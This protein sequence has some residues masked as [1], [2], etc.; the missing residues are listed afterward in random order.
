M[1]KDKVYRT[2]EFAKL[3]GVSIATLRNHWGDYGGYKV[4][5]SI[6]FTLRRFEAKGVER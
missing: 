5:G 6:F 2:E 3:I 1:D 4:R